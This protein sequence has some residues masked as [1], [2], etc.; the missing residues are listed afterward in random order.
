VHLNI[1]VLSRRGLIILLL[2]V[3][4]LGWV[5]IRQR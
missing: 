2:A 1:P 5:N 3:M 4:V